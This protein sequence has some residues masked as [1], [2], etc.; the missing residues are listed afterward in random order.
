MLL[1]GKIHKI[2]HD[3]WSFRYLSFS[4]HNLRL[5]QVRIVWVVGVGLRD[6]V[7]ERLRDGAIL[8]EQLRV[9]T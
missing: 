9:L 8:H 3:L 1:E 5:V 7:V 6:R 4:A 2:Q